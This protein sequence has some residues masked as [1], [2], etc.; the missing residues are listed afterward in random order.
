[1]KLQELWERK[2]VKSSVFQWGA[3]IWFKEENGDTLSVYWFRQLN[4]V[5]IMKNKYP[6]LRII[7]LFDQVRGSKGVFRA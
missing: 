5:V 3:P 4:K 7:E 1:M 6:L 2:Y